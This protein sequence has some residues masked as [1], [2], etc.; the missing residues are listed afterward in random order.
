MSPLA[1]LASLLVHG[2]VAA[3]LL[4]SMHEMGQELAFT[5]GVTV[6]VVSLEDAELALT[7]IPAEAAPLPELQPTRT[8][9]P[10]PPDTPRT[11]EPV[12][13]APAPE[14]PAETAATAEPA[15]L[16][17]PAPEPA[18]EPSPADTTTTEAV[19]PLPE[20]EA[21]EPAPTTSP[22]PPAASEPAPPEPA[23]AETVPDPQT[24]ATAPAPPPPA[25]SVAEPSLAPRLRPADVPP[26]V[27]TAEARPQPEGAPR[28][29][30]DALQRPQE[31]E[32]PLDALLQSVERIDRR[33]TAD[34][35]RP[36]TGQSEVAAAEAIGPN[37]GNAQL[38]RL[39]YDQIIGCWSVPAGLEG[40][41]QVG[42]VEIRTEF[43]RD[44]AVVRTAVENTQRLRT[45][46]VFR[47]VAES[48]QRAIERCTPL[49]GMPSDLYAQWRVTILVFDPTQVTAGG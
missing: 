23:R 26:P 46:R 28:P 3:W 10:T 45:D 16:E 25:E 15:R 41:R 12:G 1:L 49:R 36:G 48:A 38:G 2:A 44:G 5:D 7:Q 42:P 32:D 29:S 33:V 47:S 22:A 13:A 4:V 37:V 20:P 34:Q 9:D 24:T 35:A 17:S 21:A 14:T 30:P 43:G 39:I 18:T 27:V 6:E 11:N 8:P 40:L 31:E 19:P